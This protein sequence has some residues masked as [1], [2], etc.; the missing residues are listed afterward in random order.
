MRTVQTTAAAVQIYRSGADVTRTG[1]AELEQG[2]NELEIR[3]LSYNAVIDTVKLF[4]PA[5]IGLADI[6]FRH[7]ADKDDDT[8]E[9]VTIRE[10]ITALQKQQEILEMQANLWRENAVFNKAGVPDVKEVEGYIEKLPERLGKLN[11]A[12]DALIKERKKLEKA[13]KEADKAENLPVI[14]VVLEAPHTGTYDF[15]VHYHE[16]SASWMP[17]YEVHTDAEGPLQLKVRSRIYQHT[18]EDWKDVQ[19]SLLT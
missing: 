13:L 19:V 16:P 2:T 15:E 7:G 9:S 5:G 18:E 14:T 1:K 12:L 4:F 11:E 17:V 10:K 8:R 3:G 6:H